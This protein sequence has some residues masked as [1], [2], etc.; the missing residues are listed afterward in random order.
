MKLFRIMYLLLLSIIIIILEKKNKNIRNKMFL[1]SL[2]PESFNSV[3]GKTGKYLFEC[4][5]STIL[6]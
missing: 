6:F 3:K 2:V 5:A 1:Y 4:Q